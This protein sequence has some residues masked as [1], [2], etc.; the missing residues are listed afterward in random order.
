MRERVG[1]RL[2]PPLLASPR[3]RCHASRGESEGS[4][5][6]RALYRNTSRK[7]EHANKYTQMTETTAG[8]SRCA[9]L[10]GQGSNHDSTI[11]F[12]PGACKVN[13]SRAGWWEKS[14]SSRGKTNEGQ[15]KQTAINHAKDQTRAH[16]EQKKQKTARAPGGSHH[17]SLRG[18][19]H[20]DCLAMTPTSGQHRADRQTSN[21]NRFCSNCCHS[22]NKNYLIYYRSMQKNKT[23]IVLG[24]ALCAHERPR[25]Y[26][27]PWVL[28]LFT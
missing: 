5:S 7:F 18:C 10:P 4:F 19:Q 28:T 23:K 15:S 14:R 1:T 13:L 17:E 22:T 16:D 20:N 12:I 11:I 21:H 3:D 2:G 8:G 26:Q 9:D 6:F 27:K 25:V 24:L